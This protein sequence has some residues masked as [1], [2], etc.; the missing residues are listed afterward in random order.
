M[1]QVLQVTSWNAQGYEC[2]RPRWPRTPVAA[3]A[4]SS[5]LAR[6]MPAPDARVRPVDPAGSLDG[7]G[8]SLRLGREAEPLQLGNRQQPTVRVR[9][10][11]GRASRLVAR[12]EAEGV[13]ELDRGRVDQ[14][15]GEE[16]PE[17]VRTALQVYVSGL[18][19]LGAGAIQT[20]ATGDA[21][22]VEPDQLDLHRFERL[23]VGAEREHDALHVVARR[24][25]LSSR[26]STPRPVG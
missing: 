19:T 17:T 11:D 3:A 10:D 1:E 5:R 18:W 7:D 22:E 9:R 24:Q 21:L 26:R 25:R 4:A 23:L 8:R 2:A 6:A 13:G 20:R 16:P 15:W 14:L 12:G